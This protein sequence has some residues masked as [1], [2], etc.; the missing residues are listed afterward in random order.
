M[1][2]CD[3]WIMSIASA[4]FAAVSTDVAQETM[5]GGVLQRPDTSSF[6]FASTFQ[7][8]TPVQYGALGT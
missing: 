8:F 5:Q 7:V 6:A 1:L 4:T 2:G 3:G